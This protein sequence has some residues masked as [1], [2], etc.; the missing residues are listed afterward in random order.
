MKK[1]RAKTYVNKSRVVDIIVGEYVHE[2]G[3]CEAVRQA[4]ENARDAQATS[5]Q[6]IIDESKDHFFI[7]ND[8]PGFSKQ[9][10]DGFL[11]LLESFKDDSKTGKHGS[12]RTF[13]FR[14]SEEVIVWSHSRDYPGGL[15]VVLDRQSLT[16]F[17]NDGNEVD[18]D[19]HIEF[20]HFFPFGGARQTGTVI[21]LNKVHWKKLKG[22][23]GKENIVDRLREELSS[24]LNE[25]NAKCV[26]VNG[27]PLKEPDSLATL[28]FTQTHPTFGEVSVSLRM[29]K[30][31]AKIPYG[32]KK[33]KLGGTNPLLPMRD[34][35]ARISAD[36]ATTT[37]IVL[38]N[39]TLIGSINVT[40]VNKYRSHESHGEKALHDSFFGSDL[41]AWL[42]REFFPNVLSPAIE[43][44]FGRIEEEMKEE[45]DRLFLA[46]MV[47]DL[48]GIALDD[49]DT[50]DKGKKR[51]KRKPNNKR[52]INVD[53][54]SAVLEPGQ[55]Q[56][57]TVSDSGDFDWDDSGAK[58]TCTPK[59][60]KKVTF[61][62]GADE[63]RGVLRV[64]KR[65]DT[66]ETAIHITVS[67]GKTLTIAPDGISIPRGGKGTF[68]LRGKRDKDRPIKWSLST[69]NR[70]IKM[71][72]GAG[73][74]VADV[75]VGTLAPIGEYEIMA[76]Y[77]D[78]ATSTVTAVFHVSK[79][80]D[81]EKF[82]AL[83]GELYRVRKATMQTDLV[84]IAQRA[85]PHPTDPMQQRIGEITILMEHPLLIGTADLASKEARVL[86]RKLIILDE[87]FTRHIDLE[88]NERRLNRDAAVAKFN[89]L[90]SLLIPP[91]LS[92]KPK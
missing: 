76:C 78:D 22:R 30:P 86:S 72:E 64:M 90:R 48:Q 53:P 21:Q 24:Y 28:S 33:V 69:R 40:G 10:L 3:L 16:R 62:A 26:T 32:Y 7:V 29:P 75:H 39:D 43:R 57:F 80:E 77:T 12:G 41:Q 71:V 55:T 38:L 84:H 8:G 23:Y 82:L 87:I 17:F 42:S 9:D 56:E 88:I 73:G 18:V 13:L 47:E 6:I 85:A 52:L 66:S 5:I 36:D 67:S 27:E 37:P 58:G 54:L 65:G 92:K 61:T 59:R 83:D 46:E 60:G 70:E 44:E 49:V 20:P 51:K 34:F 35:H 15:N 11:R 79:G 89:E 45:E 31:T 74:A 14:L 25:S 91:M 1:H 63:G 2:T 50:D 81:E 68:Y 4:I 19:T